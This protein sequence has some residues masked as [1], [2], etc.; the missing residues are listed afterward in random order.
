MTAAP[1]ATPMTVVGGFLGA[2][3]TTFLNR[4][5]SRATG[6]YAVLVNDFGEIGIDARLIAH[7]DGETMTLANGCVCCSMDSGFFS[8]LARLLDGPVSFDQIIVEASGVGDPWRIAEIA[9]V[10]PKLRLHAVVV[11]ADATRIASLLRD[12]RV[13]ATVRGQFARCN[14]VLLSKSDLADEATLASARGAIAEVCESARIVE[15]SL[16]AAPDLATLD[17]PPASRFRVGA[18]PTADHEDTFR[19]WSYRRADAFDL[20][21]LERALRRLPPQVL[22]LKGF[23]RMANEHGFA[24]LQMVGRTWTITQSEEAAP[25]G[26]PGIVLVGVGADDMPAPREL[27]RILDDALASSVEGL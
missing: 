17:A 6:R 9:L 16:D 20:H 15:T 11:M 3:K 10:E 23:C 24:V 5:L 21:R 18:C 8:T 26:A 19:R 4:L 7:H 13:G 1:A 2:G 25:E 22:R 14:A 12:N 27:D